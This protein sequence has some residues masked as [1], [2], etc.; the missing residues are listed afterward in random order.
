M[1]VCEAHVQALDPVRILDEH[2]QGTPGTH[3]ALP[4]TPT[5]LCTPQCGLHLETTGAHNVSHAIMYS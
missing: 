3:S 5:D 2:L 1:K 4:Q